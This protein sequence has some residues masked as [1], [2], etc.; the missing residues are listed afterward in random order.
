MCN[1]HTHTH[2]QQSHRLPGEQL[3]LH[4][5]SGPQSEA[6]SRKSGADEGVGMGCIA[7]PGA[8]AR[9]DSDP[10]QLPMSM[11]TDMLLLA[12]LH[13]SLT[14]AEVSS[15]SPPPHTVPVA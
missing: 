5:H 15:H 12:R 14:Y 9:N 7:P 11:S 3:E 2:T 13:Q 10:D 4:L 6:T 8:E 1:R